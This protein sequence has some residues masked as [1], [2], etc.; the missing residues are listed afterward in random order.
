MDLASRPRL[1]LRRLH[2]VMGGRGSGEHRLN[3]VVKEIASNM[4]A[5]VCSVYLA[6]ADQT[7]ELFAG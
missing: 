4:E 5:E 3:R 1:L 2:K 7:L 6:R